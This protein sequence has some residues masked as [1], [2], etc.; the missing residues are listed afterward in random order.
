[1]P[2]T[3]VTHMVTNSRAKWVPLALAVVAASSLCE[4]E[5]KYQRVFTSM[6]CLTVTFGQESR[7]KNFAIAWNR[8][9]TSSQKGFQRSVAVDVL[10]FRHAFSSSSAL[11]QVN[12]SFVLVDTWMLVERNILPAEL[13][14]E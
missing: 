3:F 4:F 5:R 13:A 9:A 11:L 12:R 6:N 1:M 7:R 8:N 10:V 14:S 2:L